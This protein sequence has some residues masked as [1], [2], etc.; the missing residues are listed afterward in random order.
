V[1]PD[2][3]LKAFSHL[4]SESAIAFFAAPTLARKLRSKFPQCLHAAPLLLSTDRT[5]S[6]RR[7]A[8]WLEKFDIVPRIVG[9][10]D[11]SALVKTLA[12]HGIGAR[13]PLD[14]SRGRNRGTATAAPRHRKGGATL[15]RIACSEDRR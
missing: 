14:L 12:Q 1:P 13:V 5:T 11:D 9:E 15:R 8:A 10:L 4:L 2:A 3:G 6:R 7:L